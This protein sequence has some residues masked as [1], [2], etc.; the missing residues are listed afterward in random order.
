MNFPSPLSRCFIV[1]C[2]TFAAFFSGT[3][4]GHCD[5]WPSFRHDSSR[6]ATTKESLPTAEL[7]P[8]WTYQSPHPPQPAWAG[9]AKWDAYA[10]I[11]DLSSMRNYDSVFHVAVV[12]DSL[13]F[14][15]RLTILFDVLIRNQEK[16]SGAM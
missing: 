6:S 9:P 7:V 4:I 14:A 2:T 8:A 3:Q 16:K 5:D 13:Y 10:R 15:H 11:R 1:L 12:G